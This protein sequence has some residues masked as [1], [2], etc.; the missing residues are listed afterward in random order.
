MKASSKSHKFD[1]FNVEPKIL[2]HRYLDLTANS[3]PK[4]HIELNDCV[5]ICYYCPCGR[6]RVIYQKK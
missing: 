1:D 2:G 6:A 5:N 3:W 4:L